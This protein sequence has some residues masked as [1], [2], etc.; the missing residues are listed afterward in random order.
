MRAQYLAL[1]LACCSILGANGVAAQQG[2]PT[3]L[4]LWQQVDPATNKSEG[5]FLFFE[6]NGVY[7]GAIAKIFPRPSDDPNPLCTR[8]QGD[9]KNAP[10]LGLT[11]VKKMQR[12]GLKYENGTILDPRDGNIYNALMELSPDGQKLTVRGYL[13]I[14]LFG[15]NQTWYRLPDS[16]LAEVDR[17]VIAA[18]APALLPAVAGRPATSPLPQRAPANRGQVR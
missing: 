13:G 4:G 6:N 18:H 3:V 16:A 15:Q 10:S 1:F 14:S 2:Q 7:E 11:I 17:S 5:W 8:C 12:N 9:Q